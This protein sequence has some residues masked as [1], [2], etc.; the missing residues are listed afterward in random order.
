MWS[1]Q[2]AAAQRNRAAAEQRDALPPP[3]R[4]WSPPRA[5][6]AE[7]QAAPLQTPERPNALNRPTSTELTPEQRC[8]SPPY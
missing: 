6:E 8:A 2:Q 4:R 7:S 1:E 3:R 5:L